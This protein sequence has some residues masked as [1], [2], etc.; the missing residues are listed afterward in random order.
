MAVK[1]A[2]KHR[3]VKSAQQA[4]VFRDS[5]TVPLTSQIALKQAMK[6]EDVSDAEYNDLL[7][8]MAQESGGIVDNRNP[9]SSARGLYQLLRPQY[10]LNPNGEQSF[11]N[12]VEE[13]QGGIRYIM[14]RYGTAGKA[15][16]H[17]MANFWY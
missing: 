2:H 4:H 8:I 3:P 5:W 1:H 17:W 6:L 11:G 13:A 10:R 16:L 14:G 12:A 15:K 9:A 7:W